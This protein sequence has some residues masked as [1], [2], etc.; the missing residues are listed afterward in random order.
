MAFLIITEQSEYIESNQ[1]DKI[2]KL[3]G[4]Y[5]Y[6]IKKYIERNN[7]KVLCKEFSKEINNIPE[8]DD[9]FI[10][11]SRGVNILKLLCYN[12]LR[13]KIKNKI[14]TICETSK[15][16]GLEDILFF[17]NGKT[18]HKCIKTTMLV[19]S[20][21]FY[22]QK[23]SDK[24]TILV[25]NKY[26]KTN[27][28]NLQLDKTDWIIKSL[29]EFKKVSRKKIFGQFR[30]KTFQIIY[31]GK[32]SFYEINDLIDYEKAIDEENDLNNNKII[33][34]DQIIKYYNKAHIFIN[35]HPK[36]L[37][38]SIFECAMGGALIVSFDNFI[39]EC[40]LNQITHYIIKKE[41]V[42]SDNIDWN[43]IIN[44]INIKESVNRV[45]NKFIYQNLVNKI[46]NIINFKPKVAICFSGAIRNFER[47]IPSITKYFLNNFSNPDIFLHLWT[48]NNS[49]SNNQSNDQ[50]ND[51]SNNQPNNLITN[52]KW[53][54]STT[55]S[56]RIINILKPI[57]YV[58]EEYNSK[59]ENLIITDSGID[60]NK[61]TSDDEK[62]Y[63]INCCSMYWKIW[64]CF[65][66]MDEHSILSNIKYDIII[67]ARLDFIWED[68]IYLE[69]FKLTDNI[70]NLI[71]DRYATYSNLITNDKFFAG[72]Y[73]VMKKMSDIFNNLKKYQKLGFKL[74]G[75]VINE[76]HIKE[77]NLQHNWIGHQNTYYKHMGRHI[78]PTKNISINV[79]ILNEKISNELIYSLLLE[80]YEVTSSTNL[81]NNYNKLYD[82]YSG[83]IEN[84]NIIISNIKDN[85]EIKTKSKLIKLSFTEKINNWFKN[86]NFSRLNDLM[87]SLL[88]NLE[89]DSIKDSYVF[90]ETKQV[91]DI[92]Y[93]EKI[94]YKY[95]DHGYYNC[96]LI[97]SN[98]NK[99][100]EIKFR[101]ENILVDRDTFKIKNLINYYENGILPIN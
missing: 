93:L 90:E 70:I 50:S 22:S 86:D 71:K 44:K 29:L 18:K 26:Y 83:W 87:I 30:K 43:E 52:F 41:Q 31:K 89:S 10:T 25:E 20:E 28:I 39:K 68:N 77:L 79:N 17:I 65:E 3:S 58:I 32:K 40:Y 49:E 21:L 35:S 57:K 19:D 16:I 15:L 69:N 9:C 99:K 75:Q 56:E 14:M 60:I 72:N 33:G 85:Y 66:L 94:V 1:L 27:E 97:T 92:N 47:C 61:L 2:T 67:R 81:I 54:T 34:Y 91:I 46:I 37:G 62:N 63:G 59:W 48:F 8:A 4:I 36:S 38:L 51:Q 55:S 12:N 24:L 53:R 42:V 84:P 78:I 7:I 45:K 95:T 73:D 88:N 80:G 64:K 98:T 96:E 11:I 82:N 76:L 23:D 13:S 74:D 5:A 101:N 6:F 100:Y